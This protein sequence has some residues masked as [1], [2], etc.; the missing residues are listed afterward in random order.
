MNT[1]HT[2]VEPIVLFKYDSVLNSCHGDDV[3]QNMFSACGVPLKE[4]SSLLS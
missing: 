1:K 4:C 3:T 2:W